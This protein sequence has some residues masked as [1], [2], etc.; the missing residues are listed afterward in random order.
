[1]ISAVKDA[2]L[3]LH[4]EITLIVHYL[5]PITCR[6]VRYEFMLL[7]VIDADSFDPS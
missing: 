6:W 7:R 1:M 2:A 4:E 5:R 3:H